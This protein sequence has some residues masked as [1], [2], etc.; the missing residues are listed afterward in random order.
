MFLKSKDLS[1]EGTLNK[2][3]ELTRVSIRSAEDKLK[4]EKNIFSF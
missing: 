2:M 1:F 3:K 4:S